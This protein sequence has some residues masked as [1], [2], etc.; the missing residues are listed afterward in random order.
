MVRSLLEEEFSASAKK[1]CQLCIVDFY[2]NKNGRE[3]S[4]RLQWAV[5][6]GIIIVFVV[7]IIII[8]IIIIKGHP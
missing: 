6:A 7:I 2:L 3:A 5:A 8:I 1:L 4:S